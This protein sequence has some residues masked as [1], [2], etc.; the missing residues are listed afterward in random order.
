MQIPVLY[1]ELVSKNQP[2]KVNPESNNTA[3]KEK[4]NPESNNTAQKEKGNLIWR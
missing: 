3:Q 4:G 1:S 2:R